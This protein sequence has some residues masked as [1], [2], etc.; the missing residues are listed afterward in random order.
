[1]EELKREMEQ[2]QQ[3]DKIEELRHALQQ[4]VSAAAQLVDKIVEK[5]T[6]LGAMLPGGTEDPTLIAVTIELTVVTIASLN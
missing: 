4:D 5:K 6:K 3:Q 1:M 2:L